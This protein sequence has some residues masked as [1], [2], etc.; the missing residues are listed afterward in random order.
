MQRVDRILGQ[1]APSSSSPSPP[2]S[3]STPRPFPITAS[4]LPFTTSPLLKCQVYPTGL[5]HFTLCRPSKLNALTLDMVSSLLHHLHT[6]LLPSS[7]PPLRLVLLTGQ[8]SSFCAGGD[9][10]SIV[11]AFSAPPRVAGEAL[12]SSLFFRLEYELDAML[13][14]CP[15][16]VVAVVQGIVMGGGC[17]LSLHA[18]RMVL[19]G[20]AVVA[21]PETAIGLV[22]DVG[23]SH[24][25]GQTW[26][27]GVGM[28]AGLTGWRLTAADAMYVDAGWRWVDDGFLPGLVDDITRADWAADGQTEARLDALMQRWSSRQYQAQPGYVE[29]HRRWIDDAFTRPTLDDCLAHLHAVAR[30]SPTTAHARWAQA[31]LA[32]LHSRS[33]TSLQLT[34]ALITRSREEQWTLREALGMEYRVVL[35]LAMEGEDGDLVPGASS[36]VVRKAEAVRWRGRRTDEEVEWFLS[37]L[38]AHREGPELWDRLHV[39][40]R[41]SATGATS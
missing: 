21:F 29:T 16:P 18:R 37:P 27:W 36:K 5:A 31:T 10:K 32:L 13:A 41:S 24:A 25:L 17:G 14:E 11:D 1:V 4:Y 26:G 22:P 8:G 34:F 6:L 19:G 23:G 39:E 40:R 15:V 35:R 9:I 12:P 7:S 28:W 20:S 3:L 38:D 30:T 33:P 2:S